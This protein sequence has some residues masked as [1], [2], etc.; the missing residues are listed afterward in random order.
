MYL[1]FTL[2]SINKVEGIDHFK[3]N[4]LELGS[5]LQCH[6]MPW[7]VKAKQMG[8]HGNAKPCPTE[9]AWVPIQKEPF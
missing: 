8:S 7:A 6:D 2:V 1:S 3:Y 9:A 5:S 4:A